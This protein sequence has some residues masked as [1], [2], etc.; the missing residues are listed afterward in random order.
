M[1]SAQALV[2]DADVP[3]LPADF[4]DVIKWRAISMLDGQDG[5][6]RR[7]RVAQAEYSRLYRL[8]ATSRRAGRL[9]DALA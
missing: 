4:H 6:F 9:G 2:N 1:K 5:A 7:P 3:E 8:L